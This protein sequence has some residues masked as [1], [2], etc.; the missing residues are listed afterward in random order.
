[1]RPR[2]FH[3]SKLATGTNINQLSV[4]M[5]FF[6]VTLCYSFG[7]FLLVACSFP[8]M[9]GIPSGDFVAVCQ[10]CLNVCSDIL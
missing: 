9:L 2:N 3:E 5:Y 7:T 8:A 10:R 1:M 6:I 4:D